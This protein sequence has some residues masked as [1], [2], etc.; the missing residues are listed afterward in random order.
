MGGFP[1]FCFLTRWA[2]AAI[3]IILA[4]AVLVPEILAEAETALAVA[5]VILVAVALPVAGNRR[6]YQRIYQRISITTSS[7]GLKK[8]G[9]FGI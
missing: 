7:G 6:I 9:I 5:A 8:R 4:P 3:I 1:G 2:E